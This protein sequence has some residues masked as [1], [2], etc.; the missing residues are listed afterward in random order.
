MARRYDHTRTELENMIL[1][2]TNAIIKENG[3]HA[4]TARKIAQ[5]I[6]YSPGTLY[7]F[8]S[9]IDALILRYNGQTLDMLTARI[10]DAYV[11]EVQ[12]A[13]NGS[14]EAIWSVFNAYMDFLDEHTHRWQALF[15]HSLPAGTSLPEGYQSKITSLIDRLGQALSGIVGHQDPDDLRRIGSVLWASLHG[16]T[17]LTFAGKMSLVSSHSMKSNAA[18]LLSTFIQ[19]L[20]Q[21]EERVDADAQTILD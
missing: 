13:D 4:L 1:T 12:R 19:G 11:R 14:D 5:S 21:R 18:F 20:R 16:I 6:G 3:L 7:N 2:A 8:Y 9:N 17:S 10:E 15:D